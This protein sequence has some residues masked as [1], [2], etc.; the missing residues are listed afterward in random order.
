MKHLIPI[1][2]CIVVSLALAQQQKEKSPQ[3]KPAAAAK[4]NS[5]ARPAKVEK[6]AAKILAGEIVK[7]DSEK[8]TVTVRIKSGKYVVSVGD[9]TA[10]SAGGTSMPFSDLKQGDRVHVDYLRFSKGE[11]TATSIRD[12]TFKTK[13]QVSE[14]AGVSKKGPATVG[15]KPDTAKVSKK[16][17]ALVNAK[18]DTAKVSKKESSG[19]KAEP[20]PAAVPKPSTQEGPAK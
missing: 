20:A 4:E 14:H 2:L 18:P 9:S 3:G 11:R 12:E 10:I 13:S 8:K 16:E 1:V 15:A 5:P 17:P 19:A 6:G 7:I